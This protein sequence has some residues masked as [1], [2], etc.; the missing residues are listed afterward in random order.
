M[1]LL[2]GSRVLLFVY[3][4][5]YYYYSSEASGCLPDPCYAGSFCLVSYDF[6]DSLLYAGIWYFICLNCSV[7][8]KG[9][10]TFYLT[11]CQQFG[12]YSVG[13]VGNEL[14]R[15]GSQCEWP[16]CLRRGSA[17]A[18]FLELW[19]RIPLGTWMSICCECRVLPGRGLCDELIRRPEE[20]YQVWCVWV[21]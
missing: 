6:C 19:V 20:S 14:Y 11:P 2:S 21:W 10:V 8:W 12:S 5:Y 15:V 16:R 17:A 18:H 1:L 9:V 7:S 3:Y 4:Y 13:S